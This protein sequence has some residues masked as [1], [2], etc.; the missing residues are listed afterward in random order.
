MMP[1]S[2]PVWTI[3]WLFIA[4][5]AMNAQAA[6]YKSIDADGNVVYSDVPPSE[7]AQPVELPPINVIEPVKITPRGDTQPESDLPVTYAISIVQ[8]EAEQT[9]QNTRQF[10]VSVS[11][12]PELQPGHQLTIS[13]D[14]I[15]RVRGDQ[16]SAVVT[17]IERGAHRVTAA[18]VD[19]GGKPIT[20]SQPV[21]VYVQRRSLLQ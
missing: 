19:E 4:G 7:S 8:P 20:T 5:A 18:V 9:F 17:D 16:L 12:E 14:G 11:L 3:A 13:V 10:P 1:R 15:V 2:L 21:V 6:L